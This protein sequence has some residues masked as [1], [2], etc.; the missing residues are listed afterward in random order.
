MTLRIDDVVFLARDARDQP[1][2]LLW[3][4]YI[5]MLSLYAYAF[6]SYGAQ[7][8]PRAWQG[9]AKHVLISGIILM[10]T[11]LN[12]LRAKVIG[13]AEEWIVA[14]KVLILLVFVGIG[15][16]GSPPRPTAARQVVSRARSTLIRV[17]VR[18]R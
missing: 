8:F 14:I 7:L 12:P 17:A 16:Q 5:V 1:A 9:A 13:E 3:I 4:S 2:G 11:G 6:G 15:H 10:V 18:N